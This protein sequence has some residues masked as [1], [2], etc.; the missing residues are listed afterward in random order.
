MFASYNF[1]IVVHLAAQAG[2]RYSVQHPHTYVKNNI[3]CTVSLFETIRK[4]QSAKKPSIVYAS[5]SSVYGVHK[6]QAFQEADS[7]HP[8]SV[9][10]VSKMSTEHLAETYSQMYNLSMVGLRFFTVYGSFGRPDMAVWSFTEKLL[11]NKSIQLY[12]QGEMQRDFTHVTDISKGITSAMDYSVKHQ[13]IGNEVFNL[14]KGNVRSLK[15]FVHILI[16]SLS[17]GDQHKVKQYLQQIEYVD[18]PGGEVFYTSAD[19]AK[20]K[21]LLGF[22]PNIELE[23]GIPEFV[24]WYQTE[25]LRTVDESNESHNI[26]GTNKS[27]T[28]AIYSYNFG[29]YRGEISSKLYN[30]MERLTKFGIDAFFFTDQLK[31][32]APAGW[33]TVYT[34]LR[35]EVDGLTRSRATVKNIKF[36]GHEM[37]QQYRYWIHVDGND[38]R[39]KKLESLLNKGLTQHVLGNQ[40]AKLFVLPHHARNTTEQEMK[41]IQERGG[42]MD[43]KKWQHWN[44]FLTPLYDKLNSVRLPELNVFVIDSHDTNIMRKWAQIDDVIVQHGITR[45]QVVYS[46][47]MQNETQHIEYLNIK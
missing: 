36:K 23:Q 42:L 13:S 32:K 12:N 8:K 4:L 45:D 2:V 35:K 26:N 20:S 3:D 31:F 17:R 6:H 38:K 29:N 40:L 11:Q 15:D 19:L 16:S 46:Y 47:V 43:T 39:I 28:F 33:T 9:Y 7:L 10:A 25:W 27:H 22:Q 37:L 5:S 14:G 18:T 1:S 21:H 24:N 44:A 34:P 41:V 30:M